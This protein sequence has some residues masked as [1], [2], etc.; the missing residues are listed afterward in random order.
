MRRTRYATCSTVTARAD[1][2]R[3]ARAPDGDVAVGV[4]VADATTVCCSPEAVRR[5]ATQRDRRATQS[6][7]RGPS[8][9]H[10]IV[11]RLH[12]P[13]VKRSARPWARHGRWQRPA[14][15]R[16]G[17]TGTVGGRAL[18][19][20][21][22]LAGDNGGQAR[23]VR[24]GTERARQP[25]SQPARPQP[26]GV[27]TL[28]MCYTTVPDGRGRR[29]VAIGAG[30]DVRCRGRRSPPAAQA[31][32]LRQH[33]LACRAARCGYRH[34]LLGVRASRAHVAQRAGTARQVRPCTRAAPDAGA[35]GA[36][37][38]GRERRRA[39]VTAHAAMRYRV[40]GVR[41]GECSSPPNRAPRILNG[42]RRGH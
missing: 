13:F 40:R 30:C 22:L 16:D 4:G 23:S 42:P 18:R 38:R 32:P 26:S 5:P 19:R 31:A 36:D 21:A 34:R 15:H 25:A 20:G 10:T 24:C 7:A 28:R 37:P 3:C 1:R 29:P 2:P 6:A 33:G 41:R 27:R 12:L 39:R 9:C 11:C 8:V 14:R 35:T 17:R